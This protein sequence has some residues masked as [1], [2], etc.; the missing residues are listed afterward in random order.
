MR[1]FKIPLSQLTVYSHGYKEQLTHHILSLFREH[2]TLTLCEAD[3]T[4]LYVRERTYISLTRGLY[5]R[6]PKGRPTCL[7]T[8]QSL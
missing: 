8:E 7:L 2:A 4:L 3:L 6:S 5:E 1:D